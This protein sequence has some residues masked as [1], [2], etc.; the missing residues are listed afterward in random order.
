M[1]TLQ[2]GCVIISSAPVRCQMIQLSRLLPVL[3]TTVMMQ[4]ASVERFVVVHGQI[5]LN[6]F[7]H[8]PNKAIQSCAF[9][10]SL[11]TAMEARKHSKLY[12]STKKS[13]KSKSVNRN[14]MQVRGYH[15]VIS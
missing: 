13:L 3:I 2:E 4:L 5:L 6:Q 10:N 15:L 1:F 8:F 7:K 11:K 14:P 12:S 9:V